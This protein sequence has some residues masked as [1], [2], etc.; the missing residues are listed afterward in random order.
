[1]FQLEGVTPADGECEIV[2]TVRLLSW[3]P[4]NTHQKLIRGEL[5]Q[6][7]SIVFSLTN[8]FLAV[9]IVQLLDHTVKNSSA[10]RAHALCPET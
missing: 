8:A 6:V 7:E 5:S 4:G 3:I 9:I 1:M 2:L 10:M